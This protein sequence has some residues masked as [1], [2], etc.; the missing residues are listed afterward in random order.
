MMVIYICSVVSMFSL[1]VF[2]AT[3]EPV[4][5]IVTLILWTVMGATFAIVLKKGERGEVP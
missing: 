5:L 2:L 3:W 1:I 4:Y